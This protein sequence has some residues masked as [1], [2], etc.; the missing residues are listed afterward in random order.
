MG[1]VIEGSYRD[2]RYIG[3]HDPHRNHNYGGVVGTKDD[4]RLNYALEVAGIDW[5][6][7]EAE[8]GTAVRQNL[9]AKAN[10]GQTDTSH[11]N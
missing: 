10:I 9:I 2:S 11:L 3:F 8:E 1:V 7:E 6:E 4:A 5:L